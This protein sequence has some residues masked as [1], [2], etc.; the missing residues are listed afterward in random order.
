MLPHVFASGRPDNVSSPEV[1]PCVLR[2]CLVREARRWIL[3]ATKVG[4]QPPWGTYPRPDVGISAN[5]LTELRLVDTE[6]FLLDVSADGRCPRI[7]M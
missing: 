5:S 6:E 7:A 3:P 4:G 1:G 2:L